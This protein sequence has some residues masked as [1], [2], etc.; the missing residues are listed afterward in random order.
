VINTNFGLHRSLIVSKLS[1]IVLCETYYDT[2]NRLDVDCACDG[3]TDGQ[4]CR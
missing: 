4:N 1:Q 2:L 3:Q